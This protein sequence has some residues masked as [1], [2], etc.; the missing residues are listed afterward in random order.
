MTYTSL[1]TTEVVT[2]SAAARLVIR[3]FPKTAQEKKEHRDVLNL[4][5]IYGMD[6]SRSI[7]PAG[8]VT[9]C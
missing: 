4:Q 5:L 7:S 9:T 6:E 1:V 2:K 8:D 3:L